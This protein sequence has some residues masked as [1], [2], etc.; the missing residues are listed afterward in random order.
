MKVL[1][2]GGDGYCGWATALHLS[3]AGM[4]VTIADNLV[5]REWD[6]ALGIAPLAP[7]ATIG[8]RVHAWNKLGKGEIAYRN[9]DVVDYDA[10]AGVLQDVKPDAIVHFGQQRSAPYSMIDREHAMRTL[11]NNTAGNL[12]LLWAM[13]EVTPEA[14]LVKLGTMGEYG[15]PNIDIEEGFIDIEHKGRRDRLP[16][17]KQP[18]SFYHLTKVHDSDQIFFVCRVWG[19]R[20]TDL[21]QGV[22]YGAHT[23]QTRLAPELVNRFDYDHI[24][25]TVLNRFCV[26][27]AIGHPLTVYGL[28]GQTRSFINIRDTVRCVELAVNNPAEQGEYRVFNQFTELFSVGDLAEKVAH[29]AQNM[30]IG[31]TIQNVSNPR[32]EKEMHHYSTDNANLRSLGFEPTLLDDAVLRECIELALANRERIDRSV[33]DPTVSWRP[34]VSSLLA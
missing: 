31:V 27:A 3:A 8:E 4:D 32:S 16:F 11:V 21:H 34:R 33:I 26:Q 10:L 12:N 7:L 19:L 22:V 23:E 2:V 13:R 28:G 9:V 5:R 1:I 29:A 24:Y 17:P 18:G 25:G 30:G 20:A 14:H 15:T 6:K